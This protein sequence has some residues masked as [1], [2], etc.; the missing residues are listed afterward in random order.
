M[1]I[2]NAIL[3]KFNQQGEKTGWT[4]ITIPTEIA[5]Q[6]LP[7]NKKSF[8]TKGKIDQHTFA[9]KSL[10]PMG[11]G[12]F[13]FT[14]DSKMRKAIGKKNG[15]LVKIEISFDPSDYQLNETLMECLTDEPQALQ[16]FNSLTRSHQNY[17]SKWI[18][19]A[20]TENTKTKRIAQSINAFLK[21]QGFPEMIRHQKNL[22]NR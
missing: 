4:Y 12:D 2:F 11:K 5:Q 8:R 6:L 17:F 15:A 14:V 18:D 3:E 19:D 16:F 21:N 10:L 7:N 1:V 20:K 13:I 9:G 22:K